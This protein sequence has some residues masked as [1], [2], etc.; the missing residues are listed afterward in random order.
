MERL[1]AIQDVI[2]VIQMIRNDPE[3]EYK[4]LFEEANDLAKYTGTTISM[5]RVVSKQVG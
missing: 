2:Q 1:H 4:Y 3:E 5:P